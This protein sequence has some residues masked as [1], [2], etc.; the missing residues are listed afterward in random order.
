M[1]RTSGPSQL[2]DLLEL[3]TQRILVLAGVT[4]VLTGA[5][6]AAFEWVTR[7]Q[8][9][10]EVL[11]LPIAAQAAVLV[12]GLALTA[13]VLWV[14]GP[15]ATPATSDE[16]IRNF[17][18]HERRLSLRPALAKIA[19][20]MATLGSGGS[21]GF[22]GPS[23]YLGAVT[24]S[25]IQGRTARFFSR[26]ESKVLMV[27]GAA[28]GVAAIFKAPATGAVFALE[29]PYRDDTAKRMLLPALLAAA[30]GYLT[31]VTLLGTEPLFEV[32]GSPPFDL[33]E[34]GGA[35]LLGLVCGLG[36]R[37]FAHVVA[38]AKRLS[39]L[40]HPVVRVA[41]SGAV[42][43][44]L[45]AA[46]NAIYGDGLSSGP[47]Y[48]T[49]D[50]VT[51]PGHSL[52]LIVGLFAF[53]LAATSATLAGGGVGGL[54]VPLVI[55]GALAG[56]AAANLV[57][58]TSTLFPL[59]GV[60]AFLGA[61]YRTPLAGVMFVAETTGRP[62]FIVPGLIASVAAQ[63]V[64]GNVSVSPYQTTGRSGHLERRFLLPISTAIR[65]DVLTVPPDATLAEFY[66]GHLLL[67]RET[68]VPVVDGDAYVGMISVYDLQTVAA[69]RWATTTVDAAAHRDWP[70]GRPDWTLEQAIRALEGADVDTLPILDERG[71]FVGVVT[72]ADI[73]RLDEIL[74]QTDQP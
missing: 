19:G 66:E 58:D 43:A 8:I 38:H 25:G 40:G 69:E 33:R 53:R 55:A 30:T 65:A 56:D 1:S 71:S 49:L 22:E 32:A 3:R 73:V 57:D 45:L 64:M 70:V 14:L 10:A 50:W 74:G 4:G 59:I 34:L 48:R 28:A 36:A 15:D 60:A 29:V 5:G 7:E 26:E 24:G 54:F 39:R 6:V 67:T 2:P 52:P 68:N 21:L 46:S 9:F 72:T 18:E 13:V 51:E 37:G 17:H 63:L 23:L 11:E 27:A 44:L 41:A 20:G 62:G 16:Y 35:L 61:G 47:G 31:F 42:L 12:V